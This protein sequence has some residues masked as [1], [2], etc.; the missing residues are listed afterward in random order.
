M[1]EHDWPA[2][3]PERRS[4]DLAALTKRLRTLNPNLTSI[5]AEPSTTPDAQIRV[6]VVTTRAELRAAGG[7]LRLS[8]PA[9]DRLKIETS[10]KFL[11]Q[12]PGERIQLR[13]QRQ[14]NLDIPL[15]EKPKKQYDA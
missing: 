15:S 14:P 1:S 8:D 6:V 9:L 7:K 2:R 5:R 4:I 12:K 3:P 11:D 10:I 13:L